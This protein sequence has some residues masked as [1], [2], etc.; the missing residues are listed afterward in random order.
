MWRCNE[1]GNAGR[2]LKGKEKA[3]FVTA[4]LCLDDHVFNPP[5]DGPKGPGFPVGVEIFD[6]MTAEKQHYALTFVMEALLGDGPAPQL[7]SWNEAT[8][9]AVFEF[10]KTMIECEVDGSDSETWRRLT[11]KTWM[12]HIYSEEL[13]EEMKDEDEKSLWG[14]DEGPHQ[15]TDSEDLVEWDDKVEHL[16]DLILWDRDFESPTMEAMASPA[17]PM[18][19]ALLGIDRSYCVQAPTFAEHARRRLDKINIEIRESNPDEEPAKGSLNADFKTCTVYTTEDDLDADE[20]KLYPWMVSMNL[21]GSELK[22]RESAI[23]ISKEIRKAGHTCKMKTFG[24]QKRRYRVEHDMRYCQIWT[25]AP[26]EKLRVILSGHFAE[27]EIKVLATREEIHD[28]LR[29][30]TEGLVDGVDAPTP[31]K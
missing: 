28:R 17:A 26:L 9:Y 13:E 14:P 8:I 18:V 25:N 6:G 24:L 2:K 19:G 23:A 4:A 20:R 30:V 16:A 11:K 12:E 3:L 22:D 21:R 1:G 29:G 10:L 15:K 5:L 27:S 31:S 7:E